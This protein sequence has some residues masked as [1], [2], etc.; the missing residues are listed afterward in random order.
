MER[1]K[2]GHTEVDAAETKVFFSFF[3]HE[4]V[5]LEV[6][7][8]HTN[9]SCLKLVGH[10]HRVP[11][12]VALIFLFGQFLHVVLERLLYRFCWVQDD[13]VVLAQVYEEPQEAS[14]F[15]IEFFWSEFWYTT[16]NLPSFLLKD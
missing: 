9:Q 1:T 6:R 15:G 13:L 4:Q 12:Y 2:N 8:H 3:K 14:N 5:F 7:L 10:E 11:F 16:S